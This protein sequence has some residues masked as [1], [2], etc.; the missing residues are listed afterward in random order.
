M[1]VV[2]QSMGT[3]SLTGCDWLWM[4]SVCLLGFKELLY[5]RVLVTGII[6]WSLQCSSEQ[7]C[8]FCLCL[9]EPIV[10]LRYWPYSF[11]CYTYLQCCSSFQMSLKSTGLLWCGHMKVFY[12]LLPSRF[13]CSRFIWTGLLQEELNPELTFYV[14][15]SEIESI[16]SKKPNNP[17]WLIKYEDSSRPRFFRVCGLIHVSWEKSTWPIKYLG[18][19]KCKTWLQSRLLKNCT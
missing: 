4:E 1:H 13:L 19:C 12:S 3:E 9:M 2:R 16:F 8:P 17:T 5:L 11:F 6:L 14:S 18:N 15:L 7:I 10:I